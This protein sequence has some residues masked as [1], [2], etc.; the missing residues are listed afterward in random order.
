MISN[1]WVIVIVIGVVGVGIV[2]VGG[3][4]VGVPVHADQARVARIINGTIRRRIKSPRIVLARLGWDSFD[5]ARP[6]GLATA[7]E[8]TQY[9]V[10]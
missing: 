8:K 3:T 2:I 7:G 4:G 1:S 10:M 6:P 5:Q 9:Q